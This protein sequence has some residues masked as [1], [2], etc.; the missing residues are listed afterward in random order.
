M[1]TNR[2][3]TAVRPI[4]M[5]ADSGSSRVLTIADSGKIFTNK[6]ATGTVTFELPAANYSN[7][8]EF[9]FHIVE[10]SYPIQVLPAS[11]DLIRPGQTTTG[12]VYRS[13]MG[14]GQILRLR[15]VDNTIW[16]VTHQGGEWQ[17]V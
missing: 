10:P 8:I 1:G 9:E 6:G 3:L 15:N 14:W 16:S 17:S 7:S 11:G 4:E 2:V 5:H 12:T 13:G